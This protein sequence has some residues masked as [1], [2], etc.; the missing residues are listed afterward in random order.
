[1]NTLQEIKTFFWVQDLSAPDY[2]ARALNQGFSAQAAA[3]NVF[4]FDIVK[5]GKE[6]HISED[7]PNIIGR[8]AITFEAYAKDHEEAWHP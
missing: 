7:L 8:P 5:T 6:E 1:M 2:I 4:L 3:F